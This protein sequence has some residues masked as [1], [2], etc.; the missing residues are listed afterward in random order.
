MYVTLWETNTNQIIFICFIYFN[1]NKEKLEKEINKM[2]EKYQKGGN[3]IIRQVSP[4][5]KFQKAIIY[6]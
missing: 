3:S 6:E 2:K 4:D 5:F 1:V